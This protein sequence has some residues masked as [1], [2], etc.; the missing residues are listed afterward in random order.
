MSLVV[1]VSNENVR[2]PLGRESIAHMA[3]GT[4]RAER[5]RDA[6][7]SITVVD[8]RA[9]ARLNT[10]HLGHRGAT[11]VISFRFTRSTRADPIVG[12][13][14]ICADVAR[15]NAKARRVGVREEIAR[16]VV[17][18]VLHILGYDHPDGD[19]RERSGMWKRQERL[20][21][22]IGGVVRR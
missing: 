9:I 18:G 21:Q 14:Y 22:H 10:Q 13:V 6:F 15:K 4:L 3:R 19:G 20:M 11:D 12:D 7:V 16:L 8:R 5:V 1:D 17:H 2:S